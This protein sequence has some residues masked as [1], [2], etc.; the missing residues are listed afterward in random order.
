MK[1]AIGADH[2][3]FAH[4]EYIKKRYTD[5]EW[6][7]VGAYSDERSDYPIFACKVAELVANG[8]VQRGILLCGSGIGMVVAANRYHGVYAGLV[9]N[10]TVARLAAEHDNINIL[11]LPTDFVS[12]EQSIILVQT[13]LQAHF[14]GGRYQKRIDLIDSIK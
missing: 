10:D 6:I 2:R 11:S 1:I 5:I 7:D 9:W 12:P 4:K 14:L 8:D 3:G 13:W